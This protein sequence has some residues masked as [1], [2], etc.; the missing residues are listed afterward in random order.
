MVA[1]DQTIAELNAQLIELQESL[2]NLAKG[3]PKKKKKEIK[4]TCALLEK[5][6]EEKFEE[7]KARPRPTNSR[8]IMKI[9]CLLLCLILMCIASDIN[10]N[11]LERCTFS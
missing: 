5:R 1:D 11:T 6:I 2:L 9:P 3:T 10:I 7:H 8:H 4:N